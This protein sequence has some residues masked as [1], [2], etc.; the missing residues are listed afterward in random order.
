MDDAAPHAEAADP[1][2]RAMAHVEAHAFEP[3]ALAD[4]AA[5]AG[6]SPYHFGRQFAARDGLA[7]MAFVRARGL[8]PNPDFSRGSR[9]YGL[10][11]EA[12]GL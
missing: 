10:G 7:P 9:L 12:C 8:G 5:A 3:L 11:P 2:G 1:L 4:L 6:L